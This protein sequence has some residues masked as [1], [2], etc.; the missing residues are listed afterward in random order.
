MT[1]FAEIHPYLG[2]RKTH[3]RRVWWGRGLRLRRLVF[4]LAAGRSLEEFVWMPMCSERDETSRLAPHKIERRRP[5]VCWI[6]TRAA[7]LD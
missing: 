5:K 6:A 7:R 1:A 3:N 2:Y 4:Q